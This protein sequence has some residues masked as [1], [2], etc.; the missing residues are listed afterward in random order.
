MGVGGE[1]L[2]FCFFHARHR[3]FKKK[4]KKIT[5]TSVS[6]V[7]C[8][9]VPQ[10]VQ[11]GLLLL[12]LLRLPPPALPPPRATHLHHDLQPQQLQQLP[13]RGGHSRQPQGLS[14]R[15]RPLVEEDK[16]GSGIMEVKVE[17]EEAPEGGDVLSVCDVMV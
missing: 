1:A 16:E 13:H 2:F 7:V 4:K 15:S 5:V 14:S 12:F 8:S 10:G 17:V 3:R 9:Q 11:G 6:T